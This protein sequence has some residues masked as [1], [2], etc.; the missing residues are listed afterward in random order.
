[1]ANT[2]WKK[3][4]N[5]WEN[6]DFEFHF[7]NVL[8]VSSRRQLSLYMN[9]KSDLL[10][11]TGMCPDFRGL[12]ELVGFSYMDIKQFESASD[13]TAVL[14]DTWNS[15]YHETATIGKLCEMLAFLGRKD[16]ITE[17]QQCFEFDMNKYKE[18]TR[19]NPVQVPTISQSLIKADEMSVNETDVITVEDVDTGQESFYDAFVCYSS[20]DLWFVMQM[21]EKLEA[22]PHKLKLCIVDRD[23]IPG[24]SMHTVNAKLIEDRCRRIIAVISQNFLKSSECD[25]QLKFAHSIS[26]G[27]RSKKLIPA[28][29]EYC[30]YPQILKQITACDF[31][32]TLVQDWTWNRLAH[33][34]VAPFDFSSYSSDKNEM[35]NIHMKLPLV[36][37]ISREGQESQ[38]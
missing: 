1:M 17:C 2:E 5:N 26:P 11:S 27:S 3:L 34:I 22:P 18:V 28:I 25:F 33:A 37:R 29:I 38:E 20:C 32:K 12:A 24:A 14:L 16:C 10:S 36:R 7:Q 13:P 23:V 21:I 35:K 30:H 19:A 8:R 9:M 31:T 4:F 15:S 6:N